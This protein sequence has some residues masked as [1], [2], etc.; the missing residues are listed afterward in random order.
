LHGGTSEAV[1]TQ[2][3]SF[4]VA[5]AC[6]AEQTGLDDWSKLR[7][8]T[9]AIPMNTLAHAPLAAIRLTRMTTD[10]E[11]MHRPWEKHFRM[12]IVL[13]SLGFAA[14]VFWNP[15][16]GAALGAAAFF[17]ALRPLFLELGNPEGAA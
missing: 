10:A 1:K 4:P 13:S 11:S 7:P 14:A 8:D 2:C 6:G 16:A 5:V 17:V 15:V 12:A 3:R 9:K